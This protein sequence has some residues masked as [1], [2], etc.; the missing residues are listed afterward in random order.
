MLEKIISDGQ[1]GADLA[2]WQLAES[3]GIAVSGRMPAGLASEEPLRPETSTPLGADESI[4]ASD[5]ARIER[6][7][8]DADATLWF[9]ETTSA[10]AS[11]TVVTCRRSGKAIMLLYPGADF[12]PAHVASWIEENHIKTLNVAGNG[13]GDEPGITDRAERFLRQVLER[14]GHTPA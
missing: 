14:L 11:E 12:E 5:R 3:H 10:R 4:S 1:S 13:E 6:N 9:G 7:V 8:R 2:A